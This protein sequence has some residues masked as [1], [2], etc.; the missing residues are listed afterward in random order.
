MTAP[1]HDRAE[2]LLVCTAG[3]HLLQLWSLRQAW[4][5][6]LSRL[7]EERDRELQVI[8][9]RYR[10]PRPHRFPV[11]VVFVVPTREAVR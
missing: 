10:D 1:Q 4:Q 3:G 7:N 5:D 9:E 2:V 8:E 11:A 6:R